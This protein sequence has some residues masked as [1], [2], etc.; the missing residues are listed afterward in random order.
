M[1]EFKLLIGGRPVDGASTIN[2]INPA[3]GE[4]LVKCPRASATQ[5]EQAIAAAK[6]AFPAWSAADARDWT[7]LSLQFRR[8]INPR[9]TD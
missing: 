2:V 3:T 5:A 4:L 9:A 6:A 7:G 1:R 8:L